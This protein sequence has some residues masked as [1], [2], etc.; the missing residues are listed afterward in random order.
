MQKGKVA[1]VF[2]S[3]QGEGIYQGASQVF[4]RFFGCN[5]RCQFCDTPLKSF[6]E[7]TVG[8]LS[9]EID[10]LWQNCHSV[11]FTGGEPLL[12][13]DFLHE[14]LLLCKEKARKVYLETNGT[15]PAALE[16]VIDLVDIVAMDFKLPSSARA[17]NLWEAHERFLKEAAKKEVMVKAV[18]CNA[19]LDR[20][21]FTAVEII[22]RIDPAI[23]LVLQPNFF[24]SDEELNRK[25]AVYRQYCSRYLSDVRVLPQLHK[26]L[27][28][29]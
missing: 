13:V 22:R 12:Q 19:T 23:P 5:L 21:I 15:L 6:R 1:E 20:D 4:V 28:L 3:I 2:S 17:G 9:Q 26:I 10:S 29:R 14:I 25:L 11:S 8:E 24:D 7:Y 16:R 27:S 18:I